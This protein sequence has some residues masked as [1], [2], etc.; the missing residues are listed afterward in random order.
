MLEKTVGSVVQ[1]S[2]RNHLLGRIQSLD[3][4]GP[5]VRVN[6][7]CGFRLKALIT[8]HACQEMGLREQDQVMAL[9]KAPSIHLIARE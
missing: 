7:D 8:N 2:A 9:L 1:S 6:V 4:E 3:R 5:M